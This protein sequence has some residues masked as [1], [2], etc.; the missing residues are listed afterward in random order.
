LRPYLGEEDALES[1]MTSIQEREDDE[2]ITPSDAHNTPLDIQGPITRARTRQLNLEV[3]SFLSISFYD[4]ENRLLPND[5]IMIRNEGEDQEMLG[6]ELG[7]G[8]VQQRTSKTLGGP[9]QLNFES[10]SESRSTLP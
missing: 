4:F 5:Y 3:S 7:V 10:T 6:E 9:I 2:D 1:R 8:Q